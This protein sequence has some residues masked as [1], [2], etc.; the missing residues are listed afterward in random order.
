MVGHF[1]TG[2]SPTRVES[3]KVGKTYGVDLLKCWV[4][5]F[6]FFYVKKSLITIKTTQLVNLGGKGERY[7]KKNH[8]KTLGHRKIQ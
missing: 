4:F 1:S 5:F 6:F 2:I 7:Y 3:A 8:K